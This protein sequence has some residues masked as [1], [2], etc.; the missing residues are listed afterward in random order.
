LPNSI[1][2]HANDDRCNIPNLSTRFF[3]N[4][5]QSEFTVSTFLIRMEAP[6]N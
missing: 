3:D 4:Q 2:C 1:P 5:D 6:L